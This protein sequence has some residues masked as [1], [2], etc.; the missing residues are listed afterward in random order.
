VQV[1]SKG[2]VGGVFGFDNRTATNRV[3]RAARFTVKKQ[4]T[5]QAYPRQFNVH[6]SWILVR[7]IVNNGEFVGFTN[8]VNEFG[9][10][11]RMNWI[12]RMHYIDS[13]QQLIMQNVI[14][15]MFENDHDEVNT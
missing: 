2:I 10:D 9:Y 8:L 11:L 13:I 12:I 3:C 1:Q 14:E 5:G 6:T 15:L 7:D 4:M